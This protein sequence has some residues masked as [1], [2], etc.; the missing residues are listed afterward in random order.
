MEHIKPFKMSIYVPSNQIM[1]ELRCHRNLLTSSKAVPLILPRAE[2]PHDLDIVPL[3]VLPPGPFYI[4]IQLFFYS[5][6]FQCVLNNIRLYL[7]QSWLSNAERQSNA[8][9]L[10]VKCQIHRSLSC[11]KQIERS[12][13]AQTSLSCHVLTIITEEDLCAGAVLTAVSWPFDVHLTSTAM[14]V[15]YFN[16]FDKCK[17]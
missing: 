9:L 14:K 4:K 1:S 6:I 13:L 15:I 10:D 16:T 3:P 17:R 12:K 2:V 5:G 11:G 8:S 7:Y